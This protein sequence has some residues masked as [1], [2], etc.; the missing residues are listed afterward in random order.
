MKIRYFLT[1]TDIKIMCYYTQQSAAIENVKRRFNSEVD[2]EETY[3][4]SDFI[5]GFSHPN[6]PVILNSSQ[7]L[8]T[9]DYTWGLGKRYGI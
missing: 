2:N 7:H 9:T 4:Q 3:L 8:I 1:L 6:I 5:N